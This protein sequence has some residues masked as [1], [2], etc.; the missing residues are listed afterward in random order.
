MRGLD[1][2]DQ[3]QL[4]SRNRVYVDVYEHDSDLDQLADLENGLQAR[5]V[6]DGWDKLI[7][8]PAGNELY[9]LKHDPDDRTN[10]AAENPDKTQQLARLIESWIAK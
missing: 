8:R 4:Q 7:A 3:Q 5:V 9:D 1:L 10:L 6:I 2:R